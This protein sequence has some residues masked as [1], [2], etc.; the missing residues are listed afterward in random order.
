MIWLKL[1]GSLLVIGSTAGLGR[2]SARPYA[3]RVGTLEEWQRLLKRLMT[4]IEWKRLPLSAALG[5]AAR[6]SPR[7]TSVVAHLISEL[8][9]RD[10][11]FFMAWRRLLD[12]VPALWA[13]DR[14]VLEDLGR[15]LGRSDIAH[16]HEH[17]RAAEQ[18]LDRLIREAR[19]Q[20]VHEGRLG[21]ALLT[22]VG[23]MLAIVLL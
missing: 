22:A 10:E 2:L 11:E 12:R 19:W 6:G 17:L 3:E 13:E 7:L 20:R 16:Q 15:V 5:E 21:P 1:A 9:N 23:I 18:E 4:L 8:Q 14:A